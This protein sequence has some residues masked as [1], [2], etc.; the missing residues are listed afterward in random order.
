M[1][2]SCIVHF[3]TCFPPELFNITNLFVN[4]LRFRHASYRLEISHT[5][6]AT[7]CVLF[8]YLFSTFALA[9]ALALAFAFAIS[10]T[11]LIYPLFLPLLYNIQYTN[12][13][14]TIFQLI[15]VYSVAHCAY[16]HSSVMSYHAKPSQTHTTPNF[17]PQYRCHIISYRIKSNNYTIN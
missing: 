14:T 17:W 5:C 9:L 11:L 10:S 16:I 13:A 6:A 15:F 4:L 12:R 2:F 3:R 8:T 1:V 7:C